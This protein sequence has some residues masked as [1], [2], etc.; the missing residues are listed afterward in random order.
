[1]P[2]DRSDDAYFAPLERLKLKPETELHLG[3]VHLGDESGD[4]KRLAAASRYAR[5][6]GV[7]TECGWGRKSPDLIPAILAQHRRLVENVS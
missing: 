6:D 7:G 2:R 4:A 3:L 1:V 5:V